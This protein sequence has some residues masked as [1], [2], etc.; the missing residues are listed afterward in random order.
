MTYLSQLENCKCGNWLKES[1]GVLGR[2]EFENPEKLEPVASIDNFYLSDFRWSE[3]THSTYHW[4]FFHK[5]KTVNWYT[6]GTNQALSYKQK[7]FWKSRRVKKG[8][9]WQKS[10]ILVLNGIVSLETPQWSQ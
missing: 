6:D 8:A 9:R 1:M 5:L 7:T 2:T 10:Q 3:K 4:M